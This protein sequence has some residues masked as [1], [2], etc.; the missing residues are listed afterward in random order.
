[1]GEIKV[2]YIS[3][4]DEITVYWERTAAMTAGERFRI[5]LDGREAAVTEKTHGT[6]SGLQPERRYEI[7]VTGA[8]WC[9]ETMSVSTGKRWET[10]RN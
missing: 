3:T 7:Q 5:F 10:E 8:G 4:E 1:M 2:K 6:L 9:S